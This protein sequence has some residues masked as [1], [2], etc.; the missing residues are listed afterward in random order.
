MPTFPCIPRVNRRP[1]GWHFWPLLLA[2]P[3]LLVSLAPAQAQLIY[4]TE[5]PQ[6]GYGKN[7]PTDPYSRLMKALAAKGEK[8]PYQ[9]GRNGYLEG[10]LQALGIDLSSQMLVFSKSS[11]KQRFISPQTPRSMFFTDE[12]YVTFV[13]GSRS[14]EVAAM[15]PVLGPVFFDV[16][17]DIKAEVPF[18]QETD[19]CL[20]CH[21]TYSMTGGGVPRFMLSSVITAS[22]GNIV[23][24]ELSD[25]TDQSTPIE[26]RW[27]GWYVTGMS[28]RQMHRGNF[29]VKDVSVLSKRPW[30]GEINLGSLDQ[31]VDLAAYPRK[32][33][34][35]VALL[36]LQHQ[37]E[38][39]NRL[40][41]LNYESRKLLA[42]SS[43]TKDEELQALVKPLLEA[44]FMMDEAPLGDAV[45]GNS[46]YQQWFEQR[47]PATSD[48]KSLRQFDLN[49]RT[50]RY[51][52]S[53]LVYSD[54]VAALADRVRQLLFGDISAVL[55]GDTTLLD[56]KSLPAPER[57][58]IHDILQATKPEV[59]AKK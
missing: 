14:L 21:D 20:R 18:K 34:D 23:S 10:L 45:L 24:H 26:E 16:S 17:Q 19:R 6:M 9:A 57:Q 58:A 13:P 44:M 31:F 51:R 53:Y 25:I 36:V 43:K 5:Y 33:S 47:G 22:D 49:T 54:A 3:A 28:G 1:R 12:V 48:G 59:L 56:G 11:L 8:I 55:A 42:A 35:I 7:P 15:D 52:L 50:F 40:V 46:G 41:R 32:T 30:V 29:I 38:V 27:A 4:D 37:V 2:L 39:Q